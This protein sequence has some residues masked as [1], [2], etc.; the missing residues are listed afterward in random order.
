MIRKNPGASSLPN[1]PI[2]LTPLLDVI[3]IFLFVV[4]IGY[5]VIAEKT[6]EAAAGEIAAAESRLA[7][8]EEELAAS[9]S[10]LA[11]Y[12]ERVRDYEGQVI[13]ERVKIVTVSGSYSPEDSSRREVVVMLPEARPISFSITP[14]SMERSFGRMEA[15]IRQYVEQFQKSDRIVVV[16]SVNRTG[17]QHRDKDRIDRIIDV[18]AGEY[19]FVY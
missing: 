10:M 13:G 15:V 17:I 19:S 9:R 5:A 3:F 4:M 16:F 6:G 11:S 12:E 8:A 1:A 14:E 18:L 7:E 2:D